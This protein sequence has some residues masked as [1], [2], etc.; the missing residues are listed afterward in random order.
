MIKARDPRLTELTEIA[1]CWRVQLDL[2]S[3]YL[4]DGAPASAARCYR[5]AADLLDQWAEK[6]N[7]IL[8]EENGE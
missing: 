8:K 3:I 6:R 1:K 2:A 7:E 4:N 5:K